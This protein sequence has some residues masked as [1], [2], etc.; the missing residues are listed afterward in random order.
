MR[1][2]MRKQLFRRLSR[3]THLELAEPVQRDFLALGRRVGDRGKDAVNVFARV[4]LGYAV[5][6]GESVGKITVVHG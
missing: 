5:G 4:G 1:L 6:S 3:R 2:F